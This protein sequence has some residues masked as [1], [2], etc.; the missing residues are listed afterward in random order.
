MTYLTNCRVDSAVLTYGALTY[1][2]GTSK[3]K[4]KK[5][6]KITQ[7]IRHHIVYYPAVAE[8]QLVH[9]ES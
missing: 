5:I 7:R 4:K 6:K 9:L 2:I 8:L 1:H 3:K